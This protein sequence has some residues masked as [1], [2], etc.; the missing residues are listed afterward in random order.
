MGVG[1]RCAE[2]PANPRSKQELAQVHDYL[3][4]DTHS[5]TVY[6]QEGISHLFIP[7]YSMFVHVLLLKGF[8]AEF[9]ESALYWRRRRRRGKANQRE[10]KYPNQN[11][12]KS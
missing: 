6:K 10:E 3:P 7:Q 1:L 2:P 4:P 8:Q 9:T 12:Q 11:Y 5:I